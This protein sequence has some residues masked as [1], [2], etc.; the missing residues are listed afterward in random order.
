MADAIGVTIEGLP[1][2]KR[3]FSALTDR[4]QGKALRGALR[5]AARLVVKEAK[6]H[7]PVQTGRGKRNI[8][9]RIKLTR[10]KAEAT[11]G[12]RGPGFYLLFSELGT[13]HM[14]ARPFLRSAIERKKDE[15]VGAFREGLKKEIDK[16]AR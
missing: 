1:E 4:M 5:A 10:H 13:V 7:A 9:S 2:L 16:V 12:F 6:S 11:I 8:A 15:A 3:N 14:A